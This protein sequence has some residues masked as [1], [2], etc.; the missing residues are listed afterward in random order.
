L[1]DIG[2]ILCT[3]APPLLGAIRDD[4]L[5]VI[6]SLSKQLAKSHIPIYHH[7]VQV[8]VNPTTGKRERVFVDLRAVYPTPDEPG[9]E[10]SFEEVWAA[11]RGWLGHEWPDEVL[12]SSEEP[13]AAV[14]VFPDENAP[15]LGGSQKLTVHHDVIRLDENGAPIFPS[16][17]ESKPR[18]KKAF[19]I[20]ETQISKCPHSGILAVA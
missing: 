3:G 12:L 11:N 8:I 10:L 1:I 17:A 7:K 13:A 16:K 6:Q 9:T 18:K 14:G 19:E 2:L 5:C 20:N 15:P 4:S